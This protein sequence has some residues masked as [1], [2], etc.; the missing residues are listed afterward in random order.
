[1]VEEAAFARGGIEGTGLVVAALEDRPDQARQ[2]GAGPDLEEGAGAG[3]V[4]RLHLPCP[5]DRSGELLREQVLRRAR[6]VRIGRRRRVGQNGR[7]A[8]AQLDFLQ[9]GAQ[10]NGGGGDERRVEGGRDAQPRRRQAAGGEGGDRLLDRR[11]RPGQDRLLGRVLVGQD[12][13]EALL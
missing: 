3:G 6:F 2:P 5:L 13:V 1:E 4:Q 9:R 7:R 11:Q 12:E 8:A 10:G